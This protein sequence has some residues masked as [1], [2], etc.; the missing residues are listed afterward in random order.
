MHPRYALHRQRIGV[1]RLYDNKVSGGELGLEA[2]GSVTSRF[3]VLGFM[4]T[5][6]KPLWFVVTMACRLENV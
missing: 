3:G 6:S 2:R 5:G 1:H 4:R